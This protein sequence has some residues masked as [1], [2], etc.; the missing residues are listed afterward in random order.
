[1][2]PKLDRSLTKARRRWAWAILVVLAGI[3]LLLAG[4]GHSKAAGGSSSAK[5]AATSTA[6]AS[7]ASGGEA[8]Y[9]TA[10]LAWTRCMRANGVPD[11]PD[12][13][14]QGQF[15]LPRKSAN[16]QGGIDPNSTAFKK[17]S[18]ACQDKFPP[19]I[20][21]PATSQELQTQFLAYAR[22]MRANG[23]PNFPDPKVS[24]GRVEMMLPK[25]VSPDSQV[26]KSAQ[27]ACASKLPGEGSGAG[28]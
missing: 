10:M 1:M 19:G 3:A 4:C 22:C 25:G 26:F 6:T 5:S 7:T 17:A 12:P 23:V 11:F 14:S 13:N 15:L 27:A 20:K 8:Q 2:E 21:S 24:G 18:K 9:A 28:G 16:G